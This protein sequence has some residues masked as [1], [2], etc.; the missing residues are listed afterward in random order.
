[1]TAKIGVMPTPTTWLRIPAETEIE[2]RRSWT[3][4][5]NTNQFLLGTSVLLLNRPG[6]SVAAL[7]AAEWMDLHTEIQRLERALDSLFAPDA[8]HHALLGE[9][10]RQ[11]LVNVVPRYREA[12]TWHGERFEDELWGR[13]FSPDDRPMA[14]EAL[15]E[16]RDAIRG[17]LPIVV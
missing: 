15:V 13:M 1:M 5:L 10:D 11:V 12:R 16:L 9:L 6:G 3:L 2:V 8:Y 7:T 17:R 14:P 4:A